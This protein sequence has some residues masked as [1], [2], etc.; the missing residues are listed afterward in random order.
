MNLQPILKGELIDLQPLTPND[1]ERLY[2]V[3]SDPL[4]W[5]QHPENTRYK[6]DVFEKFFKVAIE[7]QGAFLILDKNTNVVVGSSR[8]YDFSPEK[9]EIAIGYTF[10]ARKYWGGVI[11]HELKKLML[12]HAFE[13]MNS[14]I[15]HIGEFNLRS[16]HAIE[17]I[18][19]KLIDTTDKKTTYLLKKEEFK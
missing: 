6:R 8:Y 3:A 4:V 18:G 7:S 19:A 5:E 14:V 9:S 15:F 17:K 16:R 11:N 10:I 1:F 2:A 12:S 13:F